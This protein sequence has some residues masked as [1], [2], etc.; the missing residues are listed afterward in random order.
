[1]QKYEVFQ[2]LSKLEQDIFLMAQLKVMDG[3]TISNSKRL[4]RKIRSNKRTI[5]IGIII[6][7]FVRKFILK[8]LENI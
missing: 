3:E 5:F 4:K 8:I 1:M 2:A 6:H 7:H